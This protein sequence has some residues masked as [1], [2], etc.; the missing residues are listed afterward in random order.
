MSTSIDNLL[1]YEE[2]NLEDISIEGLQ[3][4]K[5]NLLEEIDNQKKEFDEYGKMDTFIE[6][7]NNNINNHKKNLENSIW[8]QI[9]LNSSNV[10]Y[11]YYTESNFEQSK[12]EKQIE[13]KRNE[14]DE[15]H[16]N[17]NYKVKTLKMNDLKL[18]F[19]ENTFKDD[20]NLKNRSSQN[21]KT[22]DSVDI[23]TDYQRKKLSELNID[24]NGQLKIIDEKINRVEQYKK[25]AIS[26]NDDISVILNKLNGIFIADTNIE[27]QKAISIYRDAQKTGGDKI[28]D[29]KYKTNTEDKQV[30]S[31]L[32]NDLQRIINK[33]STDTFIISSI[34]YFEEIDSALA[35]DPSFEERRSKLEEKYNKSNLDLSK[36]ILEDLKVQYP[37]EEESYI[38]DFK[39]SIEEY[40]AESYTSH[41]SD[42]GNVMDIITRYNDNIEESYITSLL[43]TYKKKTDN[44]RRLLKDSSNRY[45]NELDLIDEKKY[46]DKYKETDTETDKSIKVTMETHPS[47][48]VKCHELLSGK[49]D[50][51]FHNVKYYSNGDM[52][53]ISPSKM[54]EYC[55]KLN[56]LYSPLISK[57]EL[58]YILQNNEFS[59][60][61]LKDRILS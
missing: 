28:S 40:I 36:K 13:K 7:F 42:V 58:S 14:R 32:F 54:K 31:K 20:V 30:L 56:I 18:K 46:D 16:K 38:E 59:D 47:K 43:R 11:F 22:D 57:D 37:K 9:N 15:T 4:M 41:F 12:L 44:F 45:K 10:G 21:K 6:E 25:D 35:R 34:I 24:I 51:I 55:Q 53:C 1:K 23:F 48:M 17:E 39:N 3:Q 52:S 5:H 27:E 61:E 29:H 50:S 60:K 2:M 8:K 49:I 26:K 33:V 19:F